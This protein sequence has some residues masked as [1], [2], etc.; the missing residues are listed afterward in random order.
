MIIHYAGRVSAGEGVD[1][2]RAVCGLG[3]AGGLHGTR[4]LDGQLVEVELALIVRNAAFEH[5]AAQVAIGGEVV[6]AVVVDADVRD[7]RRHL[8]DGAVAAEREKA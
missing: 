5:Q 2:T 3:P 6:E 1:K 4:Q 8:R 7:V